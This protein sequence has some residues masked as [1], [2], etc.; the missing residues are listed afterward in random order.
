MKGIL[1]RG[2][3]KF[4]N[5]EIVQGGV[6]IGLGGVDS[7]TTKYFVDDTLG[8]DG[9]S[10]L[11]WDKGNAFLTIGAAMTKA[12]T[13][14]SPTVANARGRCQIF[15]APGSYNEDVVTPLNTECPFGQLV[16]WNPTGRSFGAAYIYAATAGQPGIK[17]RARG[18]TIKGF[19]VGAL[20][21]AECI[22]LDGYNTNCNPGGLHLEDCIIGGWAAAGSIG[23]DVIGNGAP[24]TVLRNCHFN[25]IRDSAIKCSESG[26]DQPRFWEIVYC[27]FVDNSNHIKMN[28]RGFKES[29]IH[30]C[31]FMATG[32]NYSPTIILDNRGGNGCLIGPNN[33]LGGNYDETGGYYAGSNEN[34]RGNVCQDSHQATNPTAA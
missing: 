26:T 9:N 17:V 29:W 12:A 32:A 11:G 5:I 30:E 18:W 20:A 31:A 24:L 16:A 1:W 21:N 7:P 28:P 34:W 10:G 8:N 3:V 6:H 15:V 14:A 23:I 22:V 2:G 4:K 27:T 33:F 19:E 25:G 13:L